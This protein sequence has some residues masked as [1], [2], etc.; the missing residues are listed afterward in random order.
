[1]KS[2]STSQGGITRSEKPDTA[3]K[4]KRRFRE[5]KTQRGRQEHKRNMITENSGLRR[6]RILDL[7]LRPRRLP[8]F[9]RMGGSTSKG[10]QRG[11]MRKT[12][13]HIDEEKSLLRKK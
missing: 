9:R 10:K 12:R 7:K 13:G 8:G 11:R 4:E 3:P 2:A 1:M 6:E 5:E